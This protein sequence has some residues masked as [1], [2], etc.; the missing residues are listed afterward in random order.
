LRRDVAAY[1]PA[2]DP[3]DDEEDVRALA[4]FMRS[5]KAPSRGP[6]TAPVLVG[7]QVFRRIGCATCH[8][9]SI[10]TAP[11]GTVVNGGS[12]VVPM[13]LG[14]KVIYPYT[15]FLLQD[16]GTG[17]GIPIQPT[18]EYEDTAQQFRTAPLWGLRTRNRLMH[19]GMS[20]TREDAILRHAGQADEVIR[21]YR[22]LAGRDRTALLA[23]LASL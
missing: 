4:N 16:V 20:L 23:F 9:P 11:P 17:D 6:V 21:L 13:A 18:E 10:T 1:D 12:L 22:N 8:V 2:P 3:E 19:D 7:E 5:T 14:L 15:D